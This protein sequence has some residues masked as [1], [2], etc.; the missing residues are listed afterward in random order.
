MD[1]TL[2]INGHNVG[3]YLSEYRVYYETTYKRIIETLDGVLHPYPAKM[4]PVIAFTVI[5]RTDEQNE[6]LF[7]ALSTGVIPV[8]YTNTTGED[9]TRNFMLESNPE[10]IFLLKSVDG[11]RR[12]KGAEIILRALS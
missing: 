5:P 7:A 4:R 2:I 12:Y 11:K 1:V 9:E 6:T 3:S 10:S 8:T